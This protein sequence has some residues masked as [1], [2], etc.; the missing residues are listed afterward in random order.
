MRVKCTRI[1]L[2]K[3]VSRVTRDDVIASTRMDA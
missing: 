2:D 1:Q 3:C